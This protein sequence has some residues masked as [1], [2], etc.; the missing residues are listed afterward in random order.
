MFSEEEKL[1][2]DRI[3]TFIRRLSE[4]FYEEKIP[5]TAEYC[6]FNPMVPFSSRLEGR[7]KS[8]RPGRVWGKNWDHAW[9]HLTGSVPIEWKGKKIC[10][11][12][13]L[14][15]EAL[16]FSKNGT[17][18][19]GLSVASL[20]PMQDFK[21]ER[22]DICQSAR[23][24]EIVELWIEASAAQ[25]FGL[26]LMNDEGKLTPRKYGHYEACVQTIELTVFRKDIWDF[27]LDCAIL[28]DQ[29]RALPLH[30]VRRARILYTLNRAIDH[31]HDDEKGI[32][33]AKKWIH[34]ELTKKNSASSLQTIAVG[35]AHLDTAWLW[36]LDETIRKC[37]RTFANQLDLIERYPDYIF[38]ASQAQHYQFVKKNFI[39]Q[40]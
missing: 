12:I 37:A 33:K 6:K 21:R 26:Q 11:R 34:I 36:P 29:M 25:L 38:G 15:S 19:Y 8:I 35:H 17:P 28:N 23:G 40:I 13:N 14:G 10:A 22:F 1:Y 24:G 5:L 2:L 4:S 31:F 39:N 32:R 7:Y 27:Y 30:S 3:G 20:W 9:F 18:I 16:I